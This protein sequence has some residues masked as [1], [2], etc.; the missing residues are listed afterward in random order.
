MGLGV[1]GC[2]A[3]LERE[4]R[5]VLVGLRSGIYLRLRAK[6]GLMR[7]GRRVEPWTEDGGWNRCPKSENGRSPS[8]P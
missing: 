5:K 1:V 6:S 2:V 8:G 7:E 4:V 3:E